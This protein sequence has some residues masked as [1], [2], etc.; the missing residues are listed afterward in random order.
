MVMPASYLIVV[1]LL[2]WIAAAPALEPDGD[3]RI[4]RLNRAFLA[5]LDTLG[6]QQAI[7]VTALRQ[8]WRDTYSRGAE[9]SFVPD[10]LAVLYPEFRAALDAFDRH[11]ARE[12]VRLFAPLRAHADPFVAANSAYFHAR[13]QVDLGLFEE[14]VESIDSALEGDAE[15]A[16]RTPYAPHLWLLRAYCQARSLEH[17]AALESLGRL[18]RDFADAP[19]PVALGAR[20]LR[21]ETQRR[22]TGPL[23]Q[24]ASL[25]DYAAGRLDV[26]DTGRRVQTRQGEIVDLLDKLIEQQ[27]QRE[28]QGGGSASANRGG[29]QGQRGQGASG[30]PMQGRD[31]SEVDPGQGQIGELHGAPAAQP[32]EMWGKLPPAQREKILQSLRDRFPSRYRQ[33]VEQY[34]RSLAEE[35]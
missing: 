3:G 31:V 14:A 28:Q 17:D 6:P 27:Q 24:V 5:H 21:L 12:A 20:Q 1:S 33:L 8:G 7:A 18:E 19:E 26:G 2:G 29:Q 9:A 4:E 32:G 16:E 15:L 25:M 11:E 13:G 30:P 34:Y 35:K 23:A 22:Q 10:A